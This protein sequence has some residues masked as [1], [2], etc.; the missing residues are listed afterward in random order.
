MFSIRRGFS[1]AVICHISRKRKSIQLL[2]LLNDRLEWPCYLRCWPFPRPFSENLP[3]PSSQVS[4]RAGDLNHT[5]LLLTADC[6][7]FRH[8]RQVRL[9]KKWRN[10][11]LLSPLWPLVSSSYVE[12]GLWVHMTF[13]HVYSVLQRT[14]MKRAGPSFPPW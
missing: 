3:H 7:S 13:S 10:R 1:V 9:N 6:L 2:V 4:S 5:P 12:L 8:Q 14:R 11:D